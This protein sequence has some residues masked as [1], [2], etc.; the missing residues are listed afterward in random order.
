MT[1]GQVVDELDDVQR[2]LSH[3]RQ[4]QR[5]L[6]A[7]LE[8]MG[9][10]L[11]L[12]ELLTRVLHSACE[13]LDADHGSIGLVDTDRN[14]VR[15]EATFNMPANEAGAE[16]GPGVGIAGQ[17]LLTRRPVALQRYGDLERTTQPSMLEHS[18]LGM[19]IPW[20]GEM[21]G[22]LG[23]GR[24]A[25]RALG[26]AT[27]LFTPAEQ[28]TLET[29]A[30]YAAIAIR[31]AHVQQLERQRIHRLALINR[32]GRIITANLRLEELLQTAADVLHELLGYPNVAI[33]LLEAGDPDVLVIASI[34]GA[35]K[36]VVR[37]GHRLPVTQGVMG[38]AVRGRQ[39][40]LVNDV[41]RDPR[42]V[43]VP[44]SSGIVAE[45]AVPIMLGDEVLGVVNVES[46]QRL[47]RDDMEHL[48][49]VADQLAVAIENARLHAATRDLVVV[50]ERHRLARDLH[51]SVTQ[52]IFSISLV[53]QSLAPAWRRDPQEGERRTA[54]VLELSQFA[55]GEMRSMLAE[56]RSA[57]D[58]TLRLR[59]TDEH[60]AAH[61]VRRAG[62]VEAIR[63][64]LSTVSGEGVRMALEAPHAFA[65][66]A[67]VEDALFRIV[68]EALF[69]VIKH[70]HASE[71]TVQLTADDLTVRL[72]VCDDGVGIDPLLARERHGRYGLLFMRE[73]AAALGGTLHVARRADGGTLVEAVIPRETGEER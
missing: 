62:L 27:P 54:R 40:V 73:R 45:L 65:A 67:E 71:V 50:E 35:Y 28:A 63:A 69:N 61:A 4:E 36:D 9:S 1:S 72:R 11:T 64:H 26:G 53:A 68:Q 19:P 41:E 23:I 12:H 46:D 15:T 51:D 66:P 30:H 56:L 60:R 25:R 55:L 34:G 32:V 22:F 16:M 44:G 2:A 59:K 42:Y 47:T 37:G 14:V 48:R 39:A 3:L 10:D 5:S 52:L 49:F 29:F 13:L 33:P 6:S 43:K 70:A 7:L 24:S 20:R 38:A 17:V 18:V 57:E 8:A 31:V 21:I 58:A